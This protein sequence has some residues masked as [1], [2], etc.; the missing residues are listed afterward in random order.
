MYNYMLNRHF[1][2]KALTRGRNKY[3]KYLSRE[4]QT[5]QGVKNFV[6]VEN[7]AEFPLRREGC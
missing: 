1:L 7:S 5:P 6:V 4:L 3:L 2:T